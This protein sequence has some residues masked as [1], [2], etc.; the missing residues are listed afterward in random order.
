MVGRLFLL[1]RILFKVYCGGS[2][3]SAG[4]DSFQ[5]FL[6]RVDSFC[7]SG[8]FLGFPVVGRLFLLVRILFKVCCGGWTRSAGQD[9]F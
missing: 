8:F 9:S 7:L 3:F 4:E 2:A 5:G 1:V 6:W